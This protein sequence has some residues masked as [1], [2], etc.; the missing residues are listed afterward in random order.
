MAKTSSTKKP[1]AKSTRR[2]SP[3]KERKAAANAGAALRKTDAAGR[4]VRT[5]NGAT[6]KHTSATVHELPT[7]RAKAGSLE[8]LAA[9]TNPA[10]AKADALVYVVG[11]SSK[12]KR[13]AIFDVVTAMARKRAG[14]TRPDFEKALAEASVNSR[15]HFYWAKRHG[16]IVL[17]DGD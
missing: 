1:A 3:N 10:A 7:A 5:S 2:A 14:F 8:A 6:V 15:G 17:K 4:T 9:T 13:G 11:D 16:V 12:V